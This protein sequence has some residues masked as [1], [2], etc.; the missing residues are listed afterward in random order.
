MIGKRRKFG[1]V[2]FIKVV[3]EIM[4]LMLGFLITQIGPLQIK[5]WSISFPELSKLGLFYYFC[6][7][8]RIRDWF[9]VEKQREFGIIFFIE[10]VSA[11]VNFNLGF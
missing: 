8:F 1:L 2:F 5:L 11:I 4:N 10:V 6:P 7:Q 3:S 9:L